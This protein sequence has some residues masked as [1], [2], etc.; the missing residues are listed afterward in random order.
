MRR[1]LPLEPAERPQLV[2]LQRMDRRRATL[3]P[4]DMQPGLV[5]VHLAPTEV[6]DFGRPQT[7]PVRNQ[8][9]RRITMAIAVALG[10]VEQLVNLGWCQVLTG[11]Q[12]GVG[13]SPRCA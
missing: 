11:A 9:H 3:H 6:A 8:D 1:R 12:F 7:M 2:T 10:R 13:R 4:P 5:E